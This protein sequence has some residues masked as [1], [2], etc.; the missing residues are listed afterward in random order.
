MRISAI[1]EHGEILE[2]LKSRDTKNAKYW[3]EQHII[4]RKKNFAPL[5]NKKDK[6]QG[7]QWNKSKIKIMLIWDA[8]FFRRASQSL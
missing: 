8:T 2:A 1:N 3:M 7:K 6:E 5:L 4:L